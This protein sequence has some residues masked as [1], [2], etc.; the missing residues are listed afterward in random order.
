MSQAERKTEHQTDLRASS[1]ALDQ[2]DLAILRALLEHKVLTT[3]Q[4][5]VLFFRS[6]RRCQ[7]RL[8]E[9]KNLGVITSFQPRRAFGQGRS[10]E[11]HFLTNVGVCV[12][13]RR[14]GVP[15]GQLPWVPDETYK[16]N[17]NLRHRMGVNAFFCALVEASGFNE[18]HCLHRWRP[19]RKVRT[20]AGEIQPDGFGRY[21]HPGGA[22]Q[23]YLEYD[24]AT[25]GPTALTQKLRNYLTFARGW[26][27]DASFPNVLVV[28][29]R[30]PREAEVA[31][32]LAAAHRGG[33]RKAR[34][35]VFLTS[36]ALMAALGVLGPVWLP[37]D[38][39]GGRLR[40]TRLPAIDAGPFDPRRCLG[41]Y[42]TDGDGWS[43]VSPLSATPR[44]PTGLPR[45][46][47]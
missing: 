12:L 15:R 5:H 43:R 39:E 19:E 46:R 10:P 14:E 29:P 47:E 2:R 35:P 36:E 44:F 8:S 26:G 27:E 21:L 1:S 4:L 11:H 41:R 3:H 30:E 6:L 42:W 24:R 28:V 23:F 45:R 34:V 20:R 38:S 18:G 31:V 32:A 37:P 25:E 40:L 22:C 33:R 7:H 17:K 13:A 16:E 9:L